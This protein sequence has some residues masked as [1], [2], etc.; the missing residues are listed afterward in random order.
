MFDYWVGD[1]VDATIT[2]DSEGM[3]YVAAELE[4]FNDRSGELGQLIKLDPYAG[5]PYV[6][7]VPVPPRGGGDGGIWATPALG[8]GVL[9]A[10]THPGELLAVDTE[11]GQVLWRDEIG[12]HAWSSP[13]IVDDT[14]VVS[15]NCE[16]GG[17]L[18]A[19][20]VADPG[21]P[22]RL[23]QYDHAS[24]CI[25]ST[26][27]VWKGTIYVGSRDGRFYAFGEK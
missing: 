6:W 16:A 15:V 7:G 26:P 19:Y 25:E 17:G 3:L 4:R 13:V 24:G 21:N 20:S 14:L 11:T 2:I 22:S 1:D 10:S 9:Y 12:S 5:E 27:A 23:W 18:R 8:N